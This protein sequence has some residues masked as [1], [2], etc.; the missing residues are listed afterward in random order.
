MSE[1]ITDRKLRRLEN[2]DQG[3]EFKNKPELRR[4]L[5]QRLQS[6][7]QKL[8]E[9]PAEGEQTPR[10]E[11]DWFKYTQRRVELEQQKEQLD[12]PSIPEEVRQQK[13][14]ELNRQIEQL[15]EEYAPKANDDQPAMPSLRRTNELSGAE[16]PA[17]PQ[18]PEGFQPRAFGERAMAERAESGPEKKDRE[19]YLAE[20]RLKG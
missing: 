14:E 18:P 8:A 5:E 4:K 2:S 20:K 13:R 6:E 9:P 7:E 3:A 10:E 15:K 16:T 12:D 11:S 19:V 17:A 1:D